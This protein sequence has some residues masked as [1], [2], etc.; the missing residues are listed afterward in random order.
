MKFASLVLDRAF[1]VAPIRRELFGGFLEQAGRGIYG[2]VYEPSHPLADASGFR[3]DVLEL[4]RELGITSVR[5]PGGNFVSG[6]RW[7]DTVGPK[8]ERP[9]TIDLAWRSID[10]NEFGLDEFI[11]WTR[12]LGVEPR[13]A[14]N[15]GT[16]GVAEALD[17]LEYCNFPA[18][19]KQSEL[20][21]SHGAAEPYAVRTW[22]LG[23]EMD[24]PWQVGHKT[25]A[26]YARLAVETAR[27]MRQ[28]DAN[29]DLVACGSSSF[30][31]PWFGEWERVVLEE[32]YDVVDSIS[33]HQYYFEA[34][35]DRTSFLASGDHLDRYLKAL[36]ATADHVQA[37][38]RH[39]RRMSI[40]LDEWNVWY[41]GRPLA[42]GEEQDWVPGAP[43]LEDHYTVADGVVVGSMLITILQNS[44]RV[45]AAN[46][47]QL[48]N[49]I[50][51]IMTENNG[52]AWKQTTFHPFAL[53]AKATGVVLGVALTS[54]KHD[55]LVH[56]EVA[57]VDATATWDDQTRSGKIFVVNRSVDESVRL[58]VDARDIAMSQA[59]AVYI[60]GQN[61]GG[62]AAS[63]T[64]DEFQPRRNADLTLETGS[65]EI[66]LP[67]ASW[68]A[69]DFA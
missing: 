57:T 16:R 38:G 63:T 47:A 64:A 7:E 35:G 46:L 45:H 67:P 9:R 25:A 51:P 6:Y 22:Y 62:I 2:G 32:A 49:V 59:S 54:P 61:L 56:G 28:L 10:T 14:M 48:V 41:Q 21:R 65:L 4:L 31:M 40:S 5:Y 50:G 15:L 24:G 17:L 30:D 13:L 11:A 55:T 68:T 34:D 18:G 19:S 39:K 23:N 60:G 20:R 52:A 69:I 42:A 66:V 1:S 8:S 27:A 43:R 12:V 58:T 37:T 36:I 44:D 3:T 26:E 29:L 33:A 53:T